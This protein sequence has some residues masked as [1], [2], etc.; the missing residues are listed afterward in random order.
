MRRTF[1]N[2]RD[3]SARTALLREA[4]V[5]GL[6]NEYLEVIKGRLAESNPPPWTVEADSKDEPWDGTRRR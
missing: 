5:I 2:Y 3:A 1:R 4:E 6:P